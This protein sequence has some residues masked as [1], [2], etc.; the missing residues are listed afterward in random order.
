MSNSC[1]A[2]ST[3]IG[4][5]QARKKDRA[6]RHP[7]RQARPIIRVTAAS[8]ARTVTPSTGPI[9][10]IMAAGPKATGAPINAPPQPSARTR[11]L[12]HHGVEHAS[13]QVA[14]QVAA[15]QYDTVALDRNSVL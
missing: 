7:L 10:S 1:V 11:R 2:A 8:T 4:I 14:A 12:S 15:K 9:A 6:S 3:A 13:G 5:A